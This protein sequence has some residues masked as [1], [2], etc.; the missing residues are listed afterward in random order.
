MERKRELAPPV[1][2][3]DAGPSRVRQ[4]YQTQLE[5]SATCDTE[6][7][8]CESRDKTRATCRGVECSRSGQSWMWKWDIMRCVKLQTRAEL[9]G[10][11]CHRGCQG[12][13]GNDELCDS[14]VVSCVHRFHSRVLTHVVNIIS[15]TQIDEI[16]FSK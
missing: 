6:A 3:F 13:L 5:I 7:E 2:L 8:G 14:Y 4:Q 9:G 10:D 11:R 1:D 15:Q 16:V 12:K